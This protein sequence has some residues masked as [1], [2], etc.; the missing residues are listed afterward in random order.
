MTSPQR[1][2]VGAVG[3]D[4]VLNGLVERDPSTTERATLWKS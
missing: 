1:C 3:T 2:L 4:V